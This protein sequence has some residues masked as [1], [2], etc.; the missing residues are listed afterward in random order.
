M[1]PLVILLGRFERLIAGLAY[2]VM[3]AMIAGEITVR[4]FFGSTLLGS[5]KIAILS[6]VIAGFI[7]FALVTQSGR[8]LR[9][10][11]FD[12]LIPEPWRKARRRLS[13]L[14]SAA[15]LLGLTWIA[16]EFLR[17]SI[18]FRE[19][20]EV[21]YIPRWPFQSVIAYAFLSSALKHLAFFLEPKTRPIG[22]G[23]L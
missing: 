13:D 18:T 6:S 1:Q 8:H 4:E 20:V 21:L 11:A 17:D 22:D 12:G 23:G 19:K 3:T 9:V 14:I 2:I 16:F 7:G 10:S 15:L 5:E